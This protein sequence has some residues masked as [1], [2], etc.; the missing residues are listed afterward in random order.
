MATTPS[1][2]PSKQTTSWLSKKSKTPNSATHSCGITPVPSPVRPSTR[3][4]SALSEPFAPTRPKPTHAPA[5]VKAAVLDNGRLPRLRAG[6]CPL[7]LLL[8]HARIS[9]NAQRLHAPQLIL[10]GPGPQAAGCRFTA[11]T[12]VP[13][14]KAH[15]TARP[16]GRR[17]GESETRDYP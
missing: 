1:A 10:P 8:R 13:D 15:P 17:W 6:A 3:T 11:S 14:G 7:L 2:I 12:R 4:P 16:A 9:W 5:P